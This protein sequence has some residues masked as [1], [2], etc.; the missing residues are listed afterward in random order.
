[1]GQAA[2]L[3]QPVGPPPAARPL[4]PHSSPAALSPTRSGIWPNGQTKAV[5]KAAFGGM[6][7]DGGAERENLCLGTPGPG[8]AG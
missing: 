3:G 5:S 4:P 1:M 7:A 6:A 2:A 8:W